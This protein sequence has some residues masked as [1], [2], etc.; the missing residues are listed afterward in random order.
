MKEAIRQ[1]K[2]ALLELLRLNFLAVRSDTLNAT[3][4]W[5]PDEATKESLAAAGAD[6]GSIYTASELEQLVHRRVTAN[7][8]PLIHAARQR[9]GGKVINP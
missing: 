8:L 5:T 2:S 3:V 7:E 9:F 1:H 6:L 4:F